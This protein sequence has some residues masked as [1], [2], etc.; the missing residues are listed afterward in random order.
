MIVDY[1]SV[2]FRSFAR[3]P[4]VSL[5]YYRCAVNPFTSDS[6]AI[7]VKHRPLTMGKTTYDLTLIIIAIIITYGIEY[8]LIKIRIHI[9]LRSNLKI[10]ICCL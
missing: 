2:S 9:E 5:S 10:I 3:N 6:I 4:F 1:N 8:D 7:D